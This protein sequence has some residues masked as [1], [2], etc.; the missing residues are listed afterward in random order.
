MTILLRDT[1]NINKLLN[2]PSCEVN[3]KE[4]LENGKETVVSK[5]MG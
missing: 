1:C 5:E 4:S 2:I 3:V